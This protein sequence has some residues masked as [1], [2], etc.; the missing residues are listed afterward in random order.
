M[1]IRKRTDREYAAHL[2]G[3]LDLLIL[4]T[5]VFGPQHGQAIA[6]AD[7]KPVRQRAD[8]RSRVALSGAAAARGAR[9]H[10]G[11]LGHV[12]EQ[13]QGALLHA[14]RRTG[15]K[16]WCARR[17][18][19]AASPPRS[20]ACSIRRSVVERRGDPPSPDSGGQAACVACQRFFPRVALTVAFLRRREAS[21]RTSRREALPPS[22]PPAAGFD[23]RGAQLQ[24][25]FDDPLE[26]RTG[27]TALGRAV[28]SPDVRI[29]LRQDVGEVALALDAQRREFGDVDRT[30]PVVAVLDEQ[31]GLAALADPPA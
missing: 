17:A 29:V 5:L 20:C 23:E 12:G 31:P 18:S 16:S 25:A 21:L 7:S 13:P 6:R 15:R 14:D 28:R 4:R 30:R 10:R 11:G 19:G 26:H 1:S 8:R 2:Q 27:L 3:T 24:R 9:V 22:W